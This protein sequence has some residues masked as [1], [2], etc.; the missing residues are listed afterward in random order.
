MKSSNKQPLPMQFFEENAQKI[1]RNLGL[2]YDSPFNPFFVMEENGV[3]VQFADELAAL[4]EDPEFL[5]TIKGIDAATWSGGGF[6]VGEDLVIVLNRNQTSERM[7]VTI[8]EEI[9]HRHYNHQMNTL[10][11]LGRKNL[12]R[13]EEN[14]AFF[15]AAAVLL[16]AKIIAQAIYKSTNIEEISEKFGASSELIE[17]RIKQLSLWGKYGKN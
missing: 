13:D 15:T 5:K 14:E 1:R 17:M 4:F 2:D 6:F 16:P 12:N 7:N 8:L 3:K 11:S 9:S 10:D